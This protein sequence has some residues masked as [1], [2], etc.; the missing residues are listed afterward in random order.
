MASN[1]IQ[2]NSSVKVI[3]LLIGIPAAGKTTFTRNFKEYLKSV[4]SNLEIICVEFDTYLPK[5]TRCVATPVDVFEWRKHRD[6]MRTQIA[7]FLDT[8]DTSSN[9]KI[10]VLIL[11]DTFHYRSMRYEYY[12]LARGRGLGFK[13]LFFEISLEDSLCRNKTR[14][15]KIPEDTICNIWGQL[16]SP[17]VSGLNWEQD[18]IL[19]DT[20]KEFRYDLIATQLEMAA[21]NIVPPPCDTKQKLIEKE[22]SRKETLS[23]VPHKCDIFLRKVVGGMIKV[24]QE[25]GMEREEVVKYAEKCNTKRREVLRDLSIHKWHEGV[26]QFDLEDLL[27]QMMTLEV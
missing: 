23:S 16:V 27:R 7:T 20:T 18:T 2:T 15:N 13:Q 5:D 3:C 6:N 26:T 14:E 8:Q 17:I 21:T 12:R 4:D 10:S 1:T 19:V 25:S 22:V 24:A 11:D 9:S